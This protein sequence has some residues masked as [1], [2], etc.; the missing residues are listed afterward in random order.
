MPP[1]LQLLM[2]IATLAV[3]L[4]A[5]YF[6]SGYTFLELNR[7]RRLPNMLI[8]LAVG[9]LFHWLAIVGYLVMKDES[10]TSLWSRI[11]RYSSLLPAWKFRD[12][13]Q[14]HK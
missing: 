4:A 7:V 1:R 12:V 13:L 10:K 8:A 5:Y 2:A 14:K 11:A 6:L 3:V 9:W